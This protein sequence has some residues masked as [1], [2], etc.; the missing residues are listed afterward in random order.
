MIPV[1]GAGGIL[2]ETEY[3][4]QVARRE[5]F[6]RDH[7]DAEFSHDAPDWTGSIL[8]GRT[9]RGVTA[10]GLG[11][12]LDEL[13]GLALA[14]ADL[15]ALEAD[16]P[17]WRI[18]LSDIGRWWAVRQGSDGLWAKG[19]IGYPITLSAD[20][21]ADLREQLGADADLRGLAAGI[22]RESA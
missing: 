1:E 17:A 16:Y 18:W 11:L 9:R 6:R 3:G 2:K 13:D 7:P 4:R 19:R 10:Q 8:V 22:A 20:D 21:A 12:L 14:A 15:A 5:Q